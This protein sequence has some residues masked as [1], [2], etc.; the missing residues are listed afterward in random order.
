METPEAEEAMV[1]AAADILAAVMPVVRLEIPPERDERDI[2]EDNPEDEL[3]A[4]YYDAEYYI[5]I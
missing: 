5:A 3:E 4:Y 2:E 1:K